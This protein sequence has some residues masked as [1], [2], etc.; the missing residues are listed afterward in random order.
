MTIR[1]FF[2]ALTTILSLVLVGA[3]IAFGMFWSKFSAIQTDKEK[4]KPLAVPGVYNILLLGIDTRD[5]NNFKDAR[6]DVNLLC[7]VDTNQKRI[8]NKKKRVAI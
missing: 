4:T 2:K 5:T 8:K 7:T 3:L 1:K 6:S